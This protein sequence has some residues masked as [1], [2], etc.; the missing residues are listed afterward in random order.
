MP[1]DGWP[2]GLGVAADPNVR[3]GSFAS[4][5]AFSVPFV[6][7][8]VG[9]S[10]IRVRLS[11]AFVGGVVGRTG[12]LKVKRGGATEGVGSPAFTGVEVLNPVSVAFVELKA[13]NEALLSAPKGGVT[14]AASKVNMFL[15][16]LSSDTLSVFCTGGVPNEKPEPDVVP[17]TDFGKFESEV[18]VLLVSAGR[19]PKVNGD[20]CIFP[21]LSL[22]DFVAE[23]V[24]LPRPNNGLGA[25]P[26]T[27]DG[28]AV[29]DVPNDGKAVEGVD[30]L[31]A[32]GLLSLSVLL[33]SVSVAFGAGVENI[34]INDCE[35]V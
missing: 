16:S 10:S 32:A 28:N 30:T 21:E 26:L 14:G 17:K 2:K 6:S 35:G 31:A 19:A 3:E 7:I 8:L 13:R 24:T 23:T 15:L 29:L 18:E 33:A 5:E 22:P 9:L 1:P 34:L 12:V 25:S 4:V 27:G 20:F 11:S